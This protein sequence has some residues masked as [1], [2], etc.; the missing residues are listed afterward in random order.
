MGLKS[1]AAGVGVDAVKNGVFLKPLD[2]SM[3]YEA[4]RMAVVLATRS[5]Y[6]PYGL[7]AAMQMLSQLKGDGSGTSIFDTHPRRRIASPSSASCPPSSY[8]MQPQSK[9]ASA[10]RRASNAVTP[11]AAIGDGRGPI[12]G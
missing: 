12:K 11:D 6:D 3:E 1:A 5:G 8:A 10:R 2:R 9:P 4:D 7:V